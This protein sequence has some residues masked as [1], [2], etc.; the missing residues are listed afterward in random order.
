[1]TAA[2]E[3]AQTSYDTFGLTVSEVKS[4]TD[5]LSAAISAFE[6]SVIKTDISS[7]AIET[8]MYPTL[9]VKE[10]VIESPI[11]IRKVTI[12]GA[13]GI[14][15]NYVENDTSIRLDVADLPAGIYF[16]QI[17][18]EDGSVSTKRMVKM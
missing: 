18:A 7:I 6:K 14:V 2:V 5:I 13:Y 11:T 3:V 8:K 12:S 10:I 9:C 17:V 15:K 1:M 4:A 16:V